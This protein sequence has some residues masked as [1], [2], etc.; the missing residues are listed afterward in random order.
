M[1]ESS[2]QTHDIYEKWRGKTV[3]E[4][5]K[6][7]KIARNEDMAIARDITNEAWSTYL[8]RTEQSPE[9]LKMVLRKVE[10][11]FEPRRGL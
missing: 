4:L 11:V 7:E 6:A 1:F 3:S 10:E 5:S 2:K 8:S 9:H